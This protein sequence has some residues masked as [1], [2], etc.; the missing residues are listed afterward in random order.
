MTA[1]KGFLITHKPQPISGAGR[2][3]CGPDGG[4]SEAVD[5]G[6]QIVSSVEAV[7]EFG[8]AAWD[9]L[10]VDG[11]VGPCDGGLDVAERGVGPFEGWRPSRFWS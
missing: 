3:W 11:A 9:M 7:F 8:E 10:A 2:H 6:G 1:T 5:H 4:P